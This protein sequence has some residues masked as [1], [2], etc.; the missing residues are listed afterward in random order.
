MDLIYL[1]QLFLSANKTRASI[2]AVSVWH[3]VYTCLQPE[4]VTAVGG[5]V[6]AIVVG[7]LTLAG[8]MPSF[9]SQH[10]WA[11]DNVNALT[12]MCLRTGRSRESATSPAT[13]P[14]I[15]ESGNF[16]K[17]HHYIRAVPSTFR[18]VDLVDFTLEFNNGNPGRFRQAYLTFTVR[19]SASLMTDLIAIYLKELASSKDIAVIVPS[20]ISQL[21]AT[22]MTQYFSPIGGNKLGLDGQ[23]PSNRI[24]DH[25]DYHAEYGCYEPRA[26]RDLIIPTSPKIMSHTNRMSLQAM[27]RR[28]SPS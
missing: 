23:G 4:N 2:G 12:R 13:L 17:V 8:G 7:G 20:I 21:I 22:D 19:N 16:A 5:R 6:T 14:S 18:V 27:A 10:G 28:T 25:G 3:D 26:L 11:C 24:H 15:S 9:S 1:N